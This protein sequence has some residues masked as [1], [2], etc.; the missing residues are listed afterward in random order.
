MALT[1]LTWSL[2]ANKTL[3]GDYES[4]EFL[5][6]APHEDYKNKNRRLAAY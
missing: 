2:E 6:N 1:K 3:I 5:L 4:Y